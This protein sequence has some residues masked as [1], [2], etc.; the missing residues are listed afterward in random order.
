MEKTIDI[1]K[2]INAYFLK[3]RIRKAA[4]ARK[5]N[6]KSSYIGYLQKRPSIQ[7]QSLW[8]LCH[9]LQYNFFQD[10]ALLLPKSYSTTVLENDTKDETIAQ[11]QQE[12]KI[13]KAEKEVL[14]QVLKK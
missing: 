6:K 12:I 7:T 10:L 3:N 13:L 5:L 4:L 9:A 14:L 1:S 8:D 11:L 2:I